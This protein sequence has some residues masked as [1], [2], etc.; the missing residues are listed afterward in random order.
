MFVFEKMSGSQTE[1]ECRSFFDLF[2]RGGL[3]I[4]DP[5][6]QTLVKRPDRIESKLT[7][8]KCDGMN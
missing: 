8:D 5:N 3:F 4:F 1:R 2:S 7:S 6:I